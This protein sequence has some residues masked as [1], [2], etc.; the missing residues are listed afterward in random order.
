MTIPLRDYWHLLA[1]YLQPQRGRVGLL[2]LL[3]VLILVAQLVNPQLVRLFID[4]AGSTRPLAVLWQA[5]AVFITIAIIEQALL[6]AATYLS[7]RVG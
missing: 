4:A 5:A 6:I 7:E 1:R 3:L 2:A